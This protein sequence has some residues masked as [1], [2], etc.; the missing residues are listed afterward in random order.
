MSNTY[1]AQQER[2]FNRLTKKDR[3]S[4]LEVKDYLSQR[5]GVELSMSQTIQIIHKDYVGETK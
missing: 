1:T 3:E 5:M 2:A 4:L